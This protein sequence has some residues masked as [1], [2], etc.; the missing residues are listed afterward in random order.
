MPL[1]LN[2]F[3]LLNTLY[4]VKF[5][6]TTKCHVITPSSLNL[7]RL[8]CHTSSRVIYING[9]KG[10]F[11]HIELWVVFTYYYASEYK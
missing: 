11:A 5:Q 4:S 8:L 2:K 3:L 1:L 7:R 10:H 6:L 9:A